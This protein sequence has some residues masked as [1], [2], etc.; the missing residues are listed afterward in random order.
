MKLSD[1]QAYTAAA[2]R[3]AKR[4][5]GRGGGAKKKGVGSTAS[6]KKARSGTSTKAAVAAAN[7]GSGGGSSSGSSSGG[8]ARLFGGQGPYGGAELLRVAAMEREAA[9]S[10]RAYKEWV[11]HYVPEPRHALCSGPRGRT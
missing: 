10:T 3:P 4:A 7:G 1:E 8:Q 5:R 2:A 6:S 11:A 9:R